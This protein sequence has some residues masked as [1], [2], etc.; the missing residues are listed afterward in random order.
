MG[1]TSVN[2]EKSGEGALLERKTETPP[3]AVEWRRL[4]V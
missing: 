3:F 2:Q 1:P 4:D